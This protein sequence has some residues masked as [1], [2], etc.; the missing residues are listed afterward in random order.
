MCMERNKQTTLY[1]ITNAYYVNR[2]PSI[3]NVTIGRQS[4]GER[5]Y[6]TVFNTDGGDRY[7]ADL[8]IPK[9]G[10]GKIALSPD[11][12]IEVLEDSPKWFSPQVAREGLEKLFDLK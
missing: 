1:D 5:G 12:S 3:P 7:I 10:L 11:G 9:R 6:L 8:Q 2:H 4:D